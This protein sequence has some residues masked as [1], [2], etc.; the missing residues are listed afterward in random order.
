M[1]NGL[2]KLYFINNIKIFF[3]LLFIYYLSTNLFNFFLNI[4]YQK[5]D[6]STLCSRNTSFKQFQKSKDVLLLFGTNINNGLKLAIKSFRSTG[7]F[8]RIVLITPKTISLTSNSNIFL[9][10]NNVELYNVV[11]ET[12][13]VPHM[14]RYNYELQWLNENIKGVE[15]I[16]HSD[17]YDVFFQTDPFLE[18]IPKN[19]LLFIL[20]PHVFKSCGWNLAWFKE[21]YGEEK[22]IKH[23]N[24]FIICSGSIAG[25]SKFY[26]ELLTLLTHQIEWKT[27]YED[28]HDQPILNYLIWEGILKEKNISYRFIGCDGGFMTVQWC[29]LNKEILL[30]EEGY[31][32]SPSGFIPSYIH[33][34]NRIESL[35]KY[36]M[37]SCKIYE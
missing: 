2:N 11:N 15:R 36:L 27:C 10:E 14:I 20:E 31:I 33:Q 13:F 32:L 19:E 30:D 37:N 7:S 12:T 17:S 4:L 16:L 35:T 34:Y 26:L 8:A 25:S 23:L 5:N 24:D 6:F 18:L 9:L 22:L 1:K 28:S 21:C 3:I 29:V